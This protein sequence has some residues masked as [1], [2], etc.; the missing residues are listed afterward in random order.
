MLTGERDNNLKKTQKGKEIIITC[1]SPQVT[2]SG[3]LLKLYRPYLTPKRPT[4]PE[5]NQEPSNASKDN[6]SHPTQ[7]RPYQ[8]ANRHFWGPPVSERP[9]GGVILHPQAKEIYPLDSFFFFSWLL[10]FDDPKRSKSLAMIYDV[11]VCDG[12]IHLGFS[13][14]QRIFAS[15]LKFN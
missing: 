1:G 6:H 9:E 14:L 8:L 7:S 5:T 4:P 11:R 10:N 2:T 13:Q 15:L 12:S 3:V